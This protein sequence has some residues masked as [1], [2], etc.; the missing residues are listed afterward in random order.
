MPT[1]HEHR[2]YS[3]QHDAEMV[4]LSLVDARGGEYFAIVPAAD[5]KAWRERRNAALDLIDE[6]MNAGA[7][8]GQIE[9]K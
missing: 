2:A 3:V 9:V 8:P 5:G 4:R 7:Q 6:A 1:F